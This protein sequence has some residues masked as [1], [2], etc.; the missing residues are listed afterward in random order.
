M[1]SEAQR[2]VP[3]GNALRQAPQELHEIR[4]DY[5]ADELKRGKRATVLVEA[6]IS[7]GGAVEDLIVLD[8]AGEPAFAAAATQA[9]RGA[10]FR[11]A[12]DAQG[13]VASRATLAVRFTFE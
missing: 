8:D 13:P 4:P 9:V 6:F 11:P 12:Q 2:R 5:P 1:L 3:R 10:A 7:A